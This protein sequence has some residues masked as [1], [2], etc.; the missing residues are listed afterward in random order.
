MRGH[1]IDGRR[2]KREGE[3]W[4]DREAGNGRGRKRENNC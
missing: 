4:R 1:I 2:G 3:R